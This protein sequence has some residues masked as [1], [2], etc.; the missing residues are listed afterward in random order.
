MDDA[1]LVRHLRARGL[2]TSEMP[3]DVRQLPGGVS[4][5]VRAVVAPGLDVV[6]KRVHGALLVEDDWFA[7]EER[8]LTEGGALR[9]AGDLEP[10]AVPRVIDLDPRTRTLVIERAPRSWTNWRAELLAGRIDP[11]VGARL[12]RVL[13]GW[14]RETERDPGLAS[15]F[16]DKTSFVQLRIDPFHRAVAARHPDLADEVGAVIERLLSR[17]AC[18]VHG[19]FSPKNVLCG[20]DGLWVLDWEVAHVGDP[21]FDLAYLIC[22]LTLKAVHRRADAPRY[23]ETARCFLDAYGPRPADD[24]ILAANVACLLLARVD[25]KS[26]ADYLTAGERDRVRALGR[27]ML[28]EPSMLGA[29]V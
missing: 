5:E 22:H 25:G 13:S 2:V 7:D 10:L 6:V 15:A 8:L 19:D 27:G 29:Y 16:V 3:V 18:L 1:E 28:R 23:R 24:E 20:P 9:L 11:D 17:R 4:G 26:P 12:G 21:I 14:H